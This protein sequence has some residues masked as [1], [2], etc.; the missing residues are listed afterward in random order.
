MA[1]IMELD[2]GI[3]SAKSG[4]AFIPFPI[5]IKDIEE[6]GELSITF[7]EKGFDWEEVLTIPIN[8]S[9]DS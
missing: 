7:R 9:S 8:V 1:K 5:M 4:A 3:T 6:S 2:G